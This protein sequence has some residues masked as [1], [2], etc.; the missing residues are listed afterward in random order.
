MASEYYEYLG[1]IAKVGAD[2]TDCPFEC[3][4]AEKKYDLKRDRYCE[5]CPRRRQK[6]T[7]KAQA[8]E[9]VE[10]KLGEKALRAFNFEAAERKL[11]SIER[12][13]GYSP[14]KITL[15]SSILLSILLNERQASRGADA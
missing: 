12:L 10:V 14:D 13:E 15:A 11:L 4:K 1:A 9:A 5:Q 7:F 3:P 6:A 8:R 2:Y